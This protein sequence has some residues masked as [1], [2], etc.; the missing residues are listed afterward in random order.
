MLSLA[1]AIDEHGV[2]APMRRPDMDFGDPTYP[3]APTATIRVGRTIRPPVTVSDPGRQAFTQGS[4]LYVKRGVDVR[5]GDKFELPEGD[6]IVRGPAEN[7]MV[8]VL[9]GHDFGVKRY[10]IERG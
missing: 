7:D 9:D 10:N 1:E 6:F 4:L 3:D 5:D 2:D 8:N